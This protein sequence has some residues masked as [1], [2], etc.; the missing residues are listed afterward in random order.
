MP[1]RVHPRVPYKL[2]TSKRGYSRI[3]CFLNCES[4]RSSS[5]EDLQTR[6]S[7]S[8][9]RLAFH[10]WK[11][12]RRSL[13]PLTAQMPALRPRYRYLASSPRHVGP[14]FKIFKRRVFLCLRSCHSLLTILLSLQ[15]RVYF[16]RPARYICIE[17]R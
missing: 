3:L 15:F 10:K 5:R 1:R 17:I 8:H 4:R 16:D 11:F 6:R 7:T 14:L 12:I 13:S 9:H 2:Q